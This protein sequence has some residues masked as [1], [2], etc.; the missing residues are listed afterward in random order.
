MSCNVMYNTTT[1][2]ALPRAA[3]SR[4][5][6]RHW[7]KGLCMKGGEPQA[8]KVFVGVSKKSGAFIWYIV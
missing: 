3:G 2:L 6:C 4:T 8:L 5:V 7:L 1:F